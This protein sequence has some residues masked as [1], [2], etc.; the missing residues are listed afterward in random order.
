M[1]AF[2]KKVEDCQFLQLYQMVE[3]M[4][5]VTVAPGSYMWEIPRIRT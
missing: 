3:V 4:T 1:N 2:M 5:L